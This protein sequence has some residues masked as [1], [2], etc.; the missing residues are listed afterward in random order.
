MF[1]KVNE[2]DL[3]QRIVVIFILFLLHGFNS[4]MFIILFRRNEHLDKKIRYQ[5]QFRGNI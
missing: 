3:N 4:M 2:L 1:L 5:L